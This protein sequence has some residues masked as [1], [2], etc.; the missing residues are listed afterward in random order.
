M[1]MDRT[2]RI[3]RLWSNRELQRIAPLFTGD[4]VNVSGWEDRDK[5][6]GRYRDYFTSAT[7][8]FLTNYSGERGLQQLPN[9]YFL[10]L[11][12][13]VPSELRHRFDVVFNHTTLEH[14]FEVRKAFRTLCELSK[15]L[16]IVVVPFAQHQ[17]E[18]LAYGDFWRFTPTCLRRLFE[19]NGLRAIYESENRHRNAGTYLFFVG[20]RY[21]ERWADRM[22]KFVPLE[23]SASWIGRTPV[24]AVVR[25]IF[26]G[27]WR[28]L[29]RLAQS[30]RRT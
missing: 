27:G 2:A 8:Y 13:D 24:R 25:R 29:Q 11:T 4:V 22:P 20:S 7:G 3:P 12:A 15:D 18:T 10:D 23:R 1:F 16:V 14:V 28:R 17:H 9:E 26:N 5:N 6:G 30:S 19:E 21:P